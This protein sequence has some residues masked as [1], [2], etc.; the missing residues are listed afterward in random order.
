MFQQVAS[1]LWKFVSK[2]KKQVDDLWVDL[3]AAV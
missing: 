1:S 3:L 2:F